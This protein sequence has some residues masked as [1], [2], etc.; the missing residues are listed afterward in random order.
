MAFI[1]PALQRI[2]SE[3]ILEALAKVD[4]RRRAEIVRDEYEDCHCHGKSLAGWW[5]MLDQL[6]PDEY[7]EPEPPECPTF[8][9]PGTPLK[10]DVMEAR[11]NAGLALHHEEDL[12]YS[13]Y[14]LFIIWH[15]GRNGW[16]YPGDAEARIPKNAWEAANADK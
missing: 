4:I 8:A 12:P 5:Q 10:V 6:L 15:V 2:T 9:P 16:V 1:L 14:R 7:E 3:K 11:H 13:V